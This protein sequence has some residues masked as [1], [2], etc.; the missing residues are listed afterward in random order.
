MTPERWRRIE[1]VFSGASDL[2]PADREAYLDRS[3]A[4]D[5]DLRTEIGSL[6]AA[7]ERATSRLRG[8][9][10]GETARFA[11]L[12]AE[13]TRIGNHR[14]VAEIGRGGMGTVYL[15]ERD[16]GEYRTKVAIKL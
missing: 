7:S 14:L 16:D 6:L 15:A 9:V 13:G 11:A 5:A 1:E 10:G 2:P 3:C 8:I 12:P 4:G